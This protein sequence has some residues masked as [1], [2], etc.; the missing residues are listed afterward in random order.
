M[1]MSQALQ[2]SGWF[3]DGVNFRLLWHAS[4]KSCREMFWLS[5]TVYRR[6][7]FECFHGF[8]RGMTGLWR[9]ENDVSFD[10]VHVLF[11]CLYEKG[12]VFQAD[13]PSTRTLSLASSVLT[14]FDCLMAHFQ[15]RMTF[16]YARK[17]FWSLCKS[18]FYF[19]LSKTSLPHR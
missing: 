18:H 10:D 5:N 4:N 13:T 15:H 9:L 2:Y 1:S 7:I 16:W 14:R 11:I 3:V 8:G 19:V 6:A 17:L 12:D